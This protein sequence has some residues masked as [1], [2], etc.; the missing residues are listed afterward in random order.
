MPGYGGRVMRAPRVSSLLL[1]AGAAG[2]VGCGGVD[3]YAN[4][5][6]PPADINVTAAIVDGE[7]RV[8]PRAFGAGPVVLVISNQTA[9]PQRLTFETDDAGPGL[10]RATGA[11][12][13]AGTATLEV[14]V[15]RGRYAV[16]TADRSI[17]P[18][19]VRVGAPRPSAQ[20]S[21][22]TP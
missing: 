5:P 17:R 20:D 8:S 3:G 1:A 19:A 10:I 16:H 6:R 14:D 7:V 4:R 21:L 2:A 15:R 13:P 18:A 11:I 9:R 22:L 12:R